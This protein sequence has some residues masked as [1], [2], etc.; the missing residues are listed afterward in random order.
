VNRKLIKNGI[1]DFIEVG[2]EVSAQDYSELEDYVDS[3][4]DFIEDEV[5]SAKECLVDL[6]ISTL[7]NVEKCYV[8]LD[9]LSDKLYWL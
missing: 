7:D 3:V 8:M 6:S 2:I 5:N 9:E 1:L 4:L